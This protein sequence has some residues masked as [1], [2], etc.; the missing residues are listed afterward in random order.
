MSYYGF[1]LDKRKGNK[2]KKKLTIIIAFLCFA[3]LLGSVSLLLLWKSLNYDFNNFFNTGET[4]KIAVTTTEPVKTYEGRA[5]FVLGVTSDD[6]KS[7]L[8]AQIIS[9]DLGQK[10]IRVV[11]VSA[12]LN[13][14]SEK[15]KTLSDITVSGGGRAL[16]A[17]LS[18]IYKENI[19]RYV[20]LTQNEYKTVFRTMGNITVTL[21]AD[22]VYDTD[23]MFLELS[24]GE[25]D[26]TPEKIFK[27]MKYLCETLSPEEAAQKNAEL[28]AEAFASLYTTE[29]LTYSEDYFKSLINCCKSDISIVDFMENKEKLSA[30]LPA[31]SKEK[32]KVFV[33]DSVKEI[34]DED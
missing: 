4:E 26:M 7:L 27:Y 15:G 33:S 34:L 3:L 20:L 11:P 2:K 23:D 5:M 1:D 32:L 19:S 18:E 29:N 14:V 6:E 8:F 13:S 25:N 9:V 31:T 28:S 12:K 21:S 22:I 10:T 24:E 17:E 16:K 30:L